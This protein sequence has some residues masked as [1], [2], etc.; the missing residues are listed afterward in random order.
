MATLAR[1]ALIC[2]RGG[3]LRVIGGRVVLRSG[4]LLTR[5]HAFEGNSIYVDTSLVTSMSDAVSYELPVPRGHYVIIT[6][7]GA[8]SPLSMA[9]IDEAY[10]FGCA[11]GR[12]G[13]ADDNDRTAQSTPR[14]GGSCPSGHYCEVAT[15]D[16]IL[17]SNGTYC[18]RGRPQSINALQA[19]MARGPVSRP[20]LTARSA[21]RGRTARLAARETPCSAGSYAP[22]NGTETCSHC[23]AG[24]YVG[25]EGATACD[26]CTQGHYCPAAAVAPIA[27]EA[28]TYSSEKGNVASSNCTQCIPGSYCPE[29]APAPKPCQAGYK[30]EATNL[31]DAQECTACI[32]PSHSA[33]GSSSCDGCDTGYYM[34][35]VLVESPAGDPPTVRID[36]TICPIGSACEYNSSV[37]NTSATSKDASGGAFIGYELSNIVLE[38]AYWRLSPQSSEV[39]ACKRSADTSPCRGGATAGNEGDGYC[40]DGHYGPLCELCRNASYFFSRDTAQ[41]EECPKPADITGTIGVGLGGLLLVAVIIG[42]VFWQ[43]KA[44]RCVLVFFRR[45][46]IKM[47]SH[48]LIPRLSSL[49]HCINRSH[50]SRSV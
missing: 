20:S 1:A 44:C 22:M 38:P 18:P 37:Y 34:S 45:L 7:R 25:S 31:A 27:C 9:I 12:V 48:A 15:I 16:P 26:T 42:L 2:V 19:P 50:Q 21:A 17:C 33:P 49:S 11:A 36:C 29:G 8:V 24:T 10:P 47:G 41:C 6:D 35:L 43:E 39:Y 32:A 46:I 40:A 3:A 23:A 5:N 13:H 4:T 14:C 28:G 30:G